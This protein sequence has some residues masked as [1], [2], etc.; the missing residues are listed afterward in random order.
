M[1]RYV[2]AYILRNYNTEFLGN[3]I[4]F[5][6]EIDSARSTITGIVCLLYY[7]KFINI[8]EVIW[9]VTSGS[10]GVNLRK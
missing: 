10:V 7:P 3:G 1:C 4:R 6:S 9:L 2:H 5:T 8:Y